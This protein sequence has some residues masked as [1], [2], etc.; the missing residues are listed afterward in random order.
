MYL[1]IIFL[2]PLG[3]IISGFLGNKIGSIGAMLLSSG[4]LFFSCIFSTKL[5][6]MLFK[7]RN[8]LFKFKFMQKK[9]F[10]RY[11]FSNNV[12]L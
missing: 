7:L 11:Y 12:L 6:S 8:L 1:L 3:S 10:N 5:R 9:K 4:S 2:A